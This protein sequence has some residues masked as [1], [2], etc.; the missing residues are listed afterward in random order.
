MMLD[1]SF[2][3]LRHMFLIICHRNAWP[4]IATDAMNAQFHVEA[5][6]N[7]VFVHLQ[8]IDCGIPASIARTHKIA[9]SANTTS[10]FIILSASIIRC[11]HVRQ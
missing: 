10:I 1:V 9:H 4:S 11:R 7:S 3:K 8:A 6:Q 2:C 5:Y